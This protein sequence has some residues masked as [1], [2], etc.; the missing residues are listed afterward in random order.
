MI[1]PTGVGKTEIARRLAKIISAPFIKVEATKFTEIGFHGRDVDQIIRDLVD[2][3][4]FNC[5]NRIATINK[6]QISERVEKIILEALTGPAA[7]SDKFLPHL[8]AGELD[9]VVID[10]E[11]PRE[12]KVSR[13]LKSKIPPDVEHTLH[14]FLSIFQN[15]TLSAVS[16]R[17]CKVG[18]ARKVLEKKEGDSFID[19]DSILKFALHEVEHEGIVFIDEIDKICEPRDAYRS[20]DAS[21][22][23]VQRDLLP[24]IEGCTIETK[25]GN[26]DTSRI[27]FIAS[28]AFHSCKPSDMISELQ[29]RL[30]IRVELKPLSQ[31]DL[32]RI[33]KET[34]NNLISQQINLLKTENV[35]LKFTD[36][37]V[38]AIARIANQ[39]NEQVEN[40]GARRLHTII[41]RI[42]EDISFNCDA[43]AGKT[44]EL[45]E[46]Q[47]VDALGDLLKK[48]DLTKFIL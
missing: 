10:I 20:A 28:G 25:H 6:K 19:Q 37:A 34:K 45:D 42:I 39:V 2:I 23:G 3:A 30:P 35:D 4:I 38:Q 31:K 1:G 12:E 29:G 44:V 40:I 33:L 16:R 9:E 22:E 18:E 26:V 13:A 27:L 41:E 46:K 24:I 32:E 8:R 7:D 43:H 36:K 21:S 5:K 14:S 48:T 17:K 47:V 11:I 15:P